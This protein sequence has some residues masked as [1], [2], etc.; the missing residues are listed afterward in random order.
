MEQITLLGIDA[1]PTKQGNTH[2][3]LLHALK[4]ASSVSGIE[5]SLFSFYGK[6]FHPCV[7][8]MA[9]WKREGGCIY[10]QKDDLPEF[11][12]AFEKAHGLIIA[13]P[14]YHMSAPS[15]LKAALDRMG[16]ST[17]EKG[18]YRPRHTKAGGVVVQGANRFGGQEFTA[19]FLINSLLLMNCVPVAGD[20]P[21]SYIGALGSTAGYEKGIIE[22]KQAMESAWNVGVRVAELTKILYLGKKELDKEKGLPPEYGL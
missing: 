10:N 16:H 22:N 1:S 3:M 12:D 9:C 20:V 4:G 8:C 2:T 11:I 13:S 18:K 5:T 19:S 21:L 6:H 14:V 15:S 17:K 7:G